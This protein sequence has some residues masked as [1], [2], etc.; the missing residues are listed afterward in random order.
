[1][2]GLPET[3]DRLAKAGAID[4]GAAAAIKF[5]LLALAGVGANGEMV[6]PVTLRNG[7]LYLGPVRLLRI[8]PVL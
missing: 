2:R 3:L 1:M 7:S 6:V 4:R 5:A 8:S